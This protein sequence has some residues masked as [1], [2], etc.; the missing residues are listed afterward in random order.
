[1]GEQRRTAGSSTRSP[2][3]VTCT[4]ARVTPFVQ[5]VVEQPHVALDRAAQAGRAQVG[6]GGHRI[7]KIA[8]VIGRVGQNLHQGVAKIGRVRLRPVR[9]QDT[10]LVQHQLPKTGVILRQVIDIEMVIV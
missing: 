4:Q 3:V 5:A 1:M 6:F 2:A 7:L 10:Q 9:R 8:Q